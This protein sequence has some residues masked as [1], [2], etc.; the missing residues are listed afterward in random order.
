MLAIVTG[1]SSGIGKAI[2]QQLRVGGYDVVNVSRRR[3]SK[4]ETDLQYN[5]G[6]IFERCDVVDIPKLQSI[7]SRH[8]ADVLINNVGILP[9]QDFLEQTVEDYEAILNT[10]LKSAVFATQSA[11]GGMVKRREGQ[12]LNIA[13]TSG[14]HAAPDIPIY[15][16]SKAALINFTQS[17]AA[18]YGRFGVR[19]NC[20]CPGL[21]N[22]ML[23]GDSQVP[24]EQLNL[25][26]L[27][28][29][30]EP[31][32]IADLVSWIL[33]TPYLNGAVIVVDGGKTHGVYRWV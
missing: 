30:A 15:G 2:C 28:R 26:P 7:I 23:C 3:E 14:C 33:K 19:C 21:V 1:G 24:E 12:I 9:L 29:V 32:E 17:I 10:N 16:A 20:I 22:T 4:E 27:R 13:S 8:D 5:A 18:E 31:A 25:I 6:L 11:L